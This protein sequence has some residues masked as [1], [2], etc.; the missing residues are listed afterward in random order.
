[1]PK[2]GVV[3]SMIEEL[4]KQKHIVGSFSETKKNLLKIQISIKSGLSLNN[5]TN[6]SLD[7]EEDIN[8]V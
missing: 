4:F 7:S 8:K 6:D 3:Y 2:Q 5:F 1:M